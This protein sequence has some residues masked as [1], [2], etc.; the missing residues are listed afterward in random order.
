MNKIEADTEKGTIAVIGNADPFAI[1]K[2]LRKA[3]K[4]AY[5]I[6]VGPPVSPEEEKK[7]KEEEEKKKKQKEEEEKKKKEEEERKKKCPCPNPYPYPYPYSYSYPGDGYV[8]KP[9]A[10]MTSD[11]QDP[12][13]PCTIM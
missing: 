13:P 1:I 3:G 4:S 10:M 12:T 5:Y 6:T 9:F 2:R 11:Y 7:K 8:C